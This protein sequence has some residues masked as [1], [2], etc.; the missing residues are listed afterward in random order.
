M[1]ALWDEVDASLRETLKGRAPTARELPPR[2]SVSGRSAANASGGDGRPVSETTRVTALE[3][4]ARLA[5]S[6]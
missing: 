2:G 1:I 4:P 6:G 3:A 5:A